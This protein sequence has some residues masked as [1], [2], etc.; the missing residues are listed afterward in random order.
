[1]LEKL[2]QSPLVEDVDRM[3][4]MMVTGIMSDTEVNYAS[5][6]VTEVE[7][8]SEDMD[9]GISPNTEVDYAEFIRSKR[10]RV[11]SA[12]RSSQISAPEPKSKLQYTPSGVQRRRMLVIGTYRHG[13]WWPHMNPY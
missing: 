7:R 8:M 13:K 4:E 11:Q 6:I 9:A 10:Q 12:K 2:Q 1:M 5:S 3:M